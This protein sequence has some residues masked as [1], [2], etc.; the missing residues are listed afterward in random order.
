MH[1]TTRETQPETVSVTNERDE[2]AGQWV[3]LALAVR[4]LGISRA[5]VY[6]RI[7][8]GRSTPSRAETAASRF[9]YETIETK[10]ETIA[11]ISQ[12]ARFTSRATKR[13]IPS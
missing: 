4:K 2:P 3:P 8:P 7:R 5:A 12:T 9:S 6:R 10:A 1:E 11:I 13:E